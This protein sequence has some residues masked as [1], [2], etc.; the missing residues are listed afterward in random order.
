ML[1]FIK[2]VVPRKTEN[3]KIATQGTGNEKSV[4]KKNFNSK[5]SSFTYYMNTGNIICTC[6]SGRFHTQNYVI[7]TT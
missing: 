2:V 6:T 5:P 1:F 3:E 7:L 4:L